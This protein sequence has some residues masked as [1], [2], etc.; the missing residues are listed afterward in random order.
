MQISKL[1]IKYENINDLTILSYRDTSTMV[2]LST[3]QG[4]GRMQPFNI[5]MS[6]SA[7]VDK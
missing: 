5:T 6:S 1:I 2:E 7:M 3:F 4:L